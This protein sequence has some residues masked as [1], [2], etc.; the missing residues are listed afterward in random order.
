MPHTL[1]HTLLHAVSQARAT[2]CCVMLFLSS[3]EIL[4][5]FLWPLLREPGC[6]HKA[7]T[8][9]EAFALLDLH[10]KA[11]CIC[12]QYRGLDSSR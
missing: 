6:G 1:P 2:Q 5:W 8:K 3:G 7:T 9:R 4:Q 11:R 12:V 10:S